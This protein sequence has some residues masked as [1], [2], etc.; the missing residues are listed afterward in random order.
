MSVASK[1][2]RALKVSPVSLNLCPA[3]VWTIG[4]GSTR[5]STG[6]PVGPDMEPVTE[7]DAD[8]LLGCNLE[9]SER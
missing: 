5:S 7:A 9:A 3:K 1:L 2:S 6:G 8:S 4:Y